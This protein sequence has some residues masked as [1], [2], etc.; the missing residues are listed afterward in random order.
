MKKLLMWVLVAVLCCAG[1]YCAKRYYSES[2]LPNKELKD[3]DESQR[4]LFQRVRPDIEHLPLAIGKQLPEDEPAGKTDSKAE[5][6]EGT[7]PEEKKKPVSFDELRAENPDTIGWITIEGTKIDYPIVQAAD[8]QRYLQIGFDQR[9]NYGLGCPFLDYRC[10]GFEGFNSIVYA[11]HIWGN[12]AMFGDIA[13]Y[14]S[15]SFIIQHPTGKLLTEDGVH[16]V[17]FFAYMTLEENAFAYKLVPD[18]ADK[19]KRDEY[20]DNIFRSASYYYELTADELKESEDL[21]LLL[22]STCTYEY[23]EARGV[24]MGVIE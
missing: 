22:L 23:K 13:K 8:N 14:K 21:H 24:L 19:E 11:H 18:G 6:T 16:N 7:E 17:R 12:E 1:A 9:Y 10:N 3:A 20:I 5:E 15:S 2:Y 4:E